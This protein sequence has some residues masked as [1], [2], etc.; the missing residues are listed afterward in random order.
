MKKQR[1][2]QLTSTTPQLTRCDS[3]L[4][5]WHRPVRW[6]GTSTRC[7]LENL[8]K[9]IIS[10]ENHGFCFAMVPP[11]STKSSKDWATE[12]VLFSDILIKVGLKEQKR[13]PCYA[14]VSPRGSNRK[15]LQWLG[16]GHV[17]IRDGKLPKPGCFSDYFK[18]EY[19]TMLMHMEFEQVFWILY[20][21]IS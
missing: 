12:K 13:G 18:D 21:H 9:P 20:Q 5:S 15:L 3:P 17:C 1:P 19:P 11:W 4:N 7:A 16:C 10:I 8:R 2:M 6:I 14:L